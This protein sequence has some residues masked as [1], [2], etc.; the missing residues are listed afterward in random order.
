VSPPRPLQRAGKALLALW[1]LVFVAGALG[2][3]L[4]LGFLRGAT[5]VKALFLR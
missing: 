3:I 1:A 5:D 2:E 4:D